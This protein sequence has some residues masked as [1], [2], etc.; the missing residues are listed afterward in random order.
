MMNKEKVLEIKISKIN[1]EYSSWYVEKLNKY[2][3]G[4]YIC[5]SFTSNNKFYIF[6][7][8]RKVSTKFDY[9]NNNG[10]YPEPSLQIN[11]NEERKVPNFIKNE[12]VNDLKT[13]VDLINKKFGIEKRFDLKQDEEFF[14]INSRGEVEKAKYLE[15]YDEPFGN[16]GNCFKTEKAALKAINSDEWNNFWSKVK[17][18]AFDEQ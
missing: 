7:F 15:L 3:L 14:L 10:F 17:T 4:D 12:S 1:N 16:L 18:G 9:E 5:E 13:T 6:R 11:Y 2:A 8:D